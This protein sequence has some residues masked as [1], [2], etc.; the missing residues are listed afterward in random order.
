MFWD[1][2]E[3]EATVELLDDEDDEEE[4]EELFSCPS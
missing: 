3:L 4:V 1:V 2:A